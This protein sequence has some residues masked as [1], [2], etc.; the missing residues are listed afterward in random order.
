VDVR[1]AP[2]LSPT[3]EPGNALIHDRTSRRPV[4]QSATQVQKR[5]EQA[6]TRTGGQE[7]SA[8]STKQ[9]SRLRVVADTPLR[10]ASAR[11]N[12]WKEKLPDGALFYDEVADIT[13]GIDQPG[14]LVS[15]RI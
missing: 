6:A 5:G 14:L 13:A 8:D 9:P 10:T 4:R 15:V 12:V 2:L 3:H 7:T 11:Q 1:H